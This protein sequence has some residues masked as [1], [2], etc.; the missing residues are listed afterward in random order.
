MIDET[1]LTVDELAA[2]WNIKRRTIEDHCKKGKLR[3]FQPL[4]PYTPWRIPMSA[5]LE[6]EQGVQQPTPPKPEP[7]RRVKILRAPHSIH[8]TR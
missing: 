5:V 1:F 6:R 4:G 7:K 8:R 2:R 3:A